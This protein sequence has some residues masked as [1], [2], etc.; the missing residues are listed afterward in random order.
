[1]LWNLVRFHE[2]LK[3]KDT[4]KFSF[5]SW[6]KKS[7]VNKKSSTLVIQTLKLKFSYFLNRNTCFCSQLYYVVSWQTQTKNLEQ[8]LGRAPFNLWMALNGVITCSQKVQLSRLKVIVLFSN[9]SCI[10]LNSEY[11]FQFEF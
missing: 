4:E 11:I 5:L 7:F 2:I 3:H 1:M 9:F 6:Q 8:Y 10:F